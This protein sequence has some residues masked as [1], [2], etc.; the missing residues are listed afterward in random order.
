MGNILVSIDDTDGPGTPGTGELLESITEKIREKGLGRPTFIT[1]HQLLV[2]P[3]IPYTSHNSAMSIELEAAGPENEIYGLMV[4]EV[5]LSMA[6][7][8]DPG[9]CIISR[10]TISR[11]NAAKITEFGKRAQREILTKDMAYALAEETGVILSEH[12]GTGI[13]VIGAIAGVGLRLS[14][15]DGRVKG[16]FRL[17]TEN[18]LTTIAN[19]YECGKIDSITAI[20]GEKITNSDIVFI[21][22]DIKTVYLEGK[23]IL[24]IM[25]HNREN[26]KWRTLTKSEIKENY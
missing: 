24:P 5:C 20:R 4:S 13:G 16:K 6:A 8:S 15:S 3:D 17:E 2:H 25:I 7:G 10:D 14:G 1:R 21:S 26:A 23:R 22:G 12:G 11:E 19:L 18:S 9:I